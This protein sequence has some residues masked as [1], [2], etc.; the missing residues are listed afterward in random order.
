[1]DLTLSFTFRSN[2]GFELFSP[3]TRVRIYIILSWSRF[4]EEKTEIKSESDSEDESE[5]IPQPEPSSGSIKGET[6]SKSASS[7]KVW[8]YRW[9]PVFINGLGQRI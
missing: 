7:E 1:M 3:W 6:E 8:F 4:S 9:F 2:Y 5:P